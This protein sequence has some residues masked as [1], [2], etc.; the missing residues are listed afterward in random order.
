VYVT[1]VQAPCSTIGAIAV[2]N[3]AT[4]K[5]V[6]SFDTAT[7]HF[8]PMPDD[9]IETLV[10]GSLCVCVEYVWVCC[11]CV[12]CVC[13]R[14]STATI[15]FA[16]TPDDVIDT[17][18]FG[19]VCVLLSMCVHACVCVCVC[20]C[21]CCVCMCVR[22]STATIHFVTMPHD[23]IKKLVASCVWVVLCVCVLCVCMHV[24]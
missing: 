1:Y 13:V 22:E 17:L 8:A 5:R 16:P 7:I 14:E 4:G 11:V 24:L 6:Q 2:T 10:A 15:H 20:V 3:V 19:C 9:I 23:V 12:V 18:V 21:V